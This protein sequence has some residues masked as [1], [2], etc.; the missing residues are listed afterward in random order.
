MPVRVSP[1]STDPLQAILL[2]A[3]GSRRA[4]ANEDL[5]WLAEQVRTRRPGAIV[6]IA[7]LEIAGPD[8]S[9]GGAICVEQGARTV[10]MLPFFLAAGDHVTRHLAEHRDQ[11]AARFPDVAFELRGPLG[12][13]PA[14][15][16]IVLERLDEEAGR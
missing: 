5:A 15:I 10:T 8:I 12:R 11:L 1:M 16:D 7:Y 2:I 3:H 14:L 4:S 13:H 6:E 9:A